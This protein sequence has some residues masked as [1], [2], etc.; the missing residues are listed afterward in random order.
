MIFPLPQTPP[1]QCNKFSLNYKRSV[2]EGSWTNR[3]FSKHQSHTNKIKG[4]LSLS[5]EVISGNHLHK[6]TYTPM[7]ISCKL[8]TNDN[9]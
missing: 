6:P 4:T 3:T 9:P 7:T 2:N 1:N 8:S 5:K